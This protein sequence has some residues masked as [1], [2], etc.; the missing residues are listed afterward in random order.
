MS[1]E[2]HDANIIL[3]QCYRRL[4]CSTILISDLLVQVSYN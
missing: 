2:K 4:A 3:G 1:M